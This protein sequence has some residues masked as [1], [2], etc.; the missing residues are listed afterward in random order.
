MAADPQTGALAQ[1]A[2]L[3]AQSGRMDEAARLWAQVRANVPDHPQALLFLGQHMLVRARNPQG[4]IEFLTRAASV[5]AKNPVIPLNLAFAYRAL[6]DSQNEMAALIR[7]LSID[8]YFFPALLSKAILEERSGQQRT[9][10]KT[11]KDVLT[12]APPDEQLSP[13][14]RGAV[15][16][17]RDV[18]RE[19]AAALDGFLA[20]RLSVA[21]ARH[22][23]ENLDRFEQCKDIA[24]GTKKAYTQQP[25]LLLFPGL[26][27]IQ[28]YDRDLFPWLSELESDTDVIRQELLA[29]MREDSDDFKPYVDHPAGSP[30]TQWRELNHSPRWSVLFL[31][32]DGKR[33]EDVCQRCPRTAAAIERVPTMNVVNFAPTIMFSTLAPH[34]HIPPHSSVTN[35]RLVVHLPL[36][37][38][39]N[40]RF[41]VGNET[42]EWREGEAWVFDDTI[43]H[44]AWNDSESLRVILMIDIWNPFLTE[45]ERDLVSELLNGVRDYYAG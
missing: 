38:P 30:G 23:N 12:I 35:A 6:A 36:I 9:A 21:R 11:Y 37:V 20:E 18:V 3:A 33:R 13:E 19:N 22:Q 31:W 2:Q 4:A 29:A 39:P 32:K 5:D 8:P 26:P 10:A 27:A 42:R 15:A 7:A 24:V 43:D 41:R 44:E 1:A 25:S 45:A 34:T 40:C 16:H 14:M 17:A 28:F